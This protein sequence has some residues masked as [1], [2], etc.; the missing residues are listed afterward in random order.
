MVISSSNAAGGLNYIP[1][2]T[3]GRQP[4]T[5]K[6]D[7]FDA[8]SR[9]AT[10]SSLNYVRFMLPSSSQGILYFDYHAALLR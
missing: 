2:S 5:F 7:D 4:V 10:N 9:S 3:M 6:S 8:V 1:Y